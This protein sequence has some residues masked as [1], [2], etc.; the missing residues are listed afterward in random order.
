VRE[1]FAS[2]AVE[3]GRATGFAASF[4]A[5]RK[6]IVAIV[7]F[8]AAMNVLM[9][10]GPLYMMQVFDRVLSSRSMETLA[11]LT[12][13][14]IVALA[15]MAAIEIVRSALAV[16]IGAFLDQR[17]GP[18]SL[19][20]MIHSAVQGRSVGVQPLRDL[21]QIRGYCTSNAAFAVCD[22]PWLPIYLG[23]VFLIHPIL[24]V[25]AV[26]GAFILFVV[27][28]LNEFATRR[29]L[30]G[31]AEK[32]NR[33]MQRAEA[34][35]RNAEVVEAMG[36]L[37]GIGQRWH[38]E[39]RV[40][41]ELQTKGADRA[42]L[43]QSIA[44]FLRMVIQVAMY[45]AGAWFVVN[46]QI[47]A[48]AMMAATIIMAR[49]LA[50]VEQ[51]IGGWRIMLG[52]RDAYSRLKSFFAEPPRA[53]TMSLP[54][55]AGRITVERL[56]YAPRG[57]LRVLLKGISFQIEPGEAVAIAGPSGAGKSTLARALVG[58]IAPNA[59]HVRLDGAELHRWNRMEFGAFV[60]YLP[61]GVELF[62]GTVRDNIARLAEAED[63]DVVAA[64]K[65]ADVHDL[66]LRLP[67]GYHTKIGDGGTKLSA[68]QRQRIALARAVFGRPRLVVMDEPD[69]SLDVDG[70]AAL[71]RA[72]SQLRADG[73]TVIVVTHRPRL[74]AVVDKV[75]ILRDGAVDAFGPAGAVME[76][77]RAPVPIAPAQSAK[78]IPAK[79]PPGSV[80]RPIREVARS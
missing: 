70:E 62:D 71:E 74:L 16:R 44:R 5:C 24:G 42:A 15:V 65:L 50:P 33:S 57:S 34:A 32:Q 58:V 18:E 10:T 56:T 27:A 43:Y 30:S 22:A 14:A 8:S 75:L 12:L 60:G 68:G 13:I 77:L 39:S 59:G 47:T 63:A 64:A 55:P 73:A 51:A 40:G 17:L 49:G 37:H 19:D 21:A 67:Y 20:R 76:R 66:I 79:P 1:P 80:A 69:S 26:L 31:A 11:Y 3:R 46:Q 41:S 25:I 28:V 48:G 9:L 35:V 61:Q 4:R 2:S 45:A 54:E 29:A 7:A 53:E 6:A 52:T 78:I 38:Q 23:V 36:M 72:I